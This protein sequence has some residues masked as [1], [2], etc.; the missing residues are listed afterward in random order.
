MSNLDTIYM[1]VFSWLLEKK[2]ILNIPGM[3]LRVTI[4]PSD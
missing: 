1:F 3:N 4:I 2:N